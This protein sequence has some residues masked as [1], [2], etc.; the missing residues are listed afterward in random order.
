MSLRQLGLLTFFLL[1]IGGLLYAGICWWSIPV[2]LIPIKVIAPPA[3]VAGGRDW[4]S[5]RGVEVGILEKQDCGPFSGDFFMPQ[6]LGSGVAAFDA[7]GDGRVDLFF[8]NCGGPKGAPNRLYLQTALDH[9]QLAPAGNGLDLSHYCTGVAIGD[10]NRDGKP[11]VLLAEY[12]GIQLLLNAGGG[13]FRRCPSPSSMQ[14]PDWATSCAIADLNGDQLPDLVVTN[15]VAFDPAWPCT[16]PSG[17]REFCPPSAFPGRMTR[18]FKNL[19]SKPGGDP[20]F[21]DVTSFSGLAELPGPG[22][23]V[24]IAD[25]GGSNLP[26][27]LVANDGKPNHLWI[28]QGGF[29][30]SEQALTR[31]LA[32]GG[33]GRAQAGMGIALGDFAGQGRIDVFMTHLAEETHGLWVQGEGGRFR[34]RGA[35]LGVMRTHWRGTGFG[36]VAVDFNLDGR[37]DLALANG[38][39]ASDPQRTQ[40]QG[41]DLAEKWMAGYLQKNQLFQGQL[42]GQ[43]E[44]LSPQIT[45][46]C[47]LPGIH[48]GMVSADLN[49]DGRPDLIVTRLGQRPLILYNQS[50]NRGTALEFHDVNG[51]LQT[52]PIR[53]ILPDGR[54]RILALGGSYLSASEALVFIAP[55][56]DLA[57]N[58]GGV[59]VIWPGGEREQFVL[60][61]EKPRQVVR[62]GQGKRENPST[63]Q[64]AKP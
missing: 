22:L 48:R 18:V 4:F 58:P 38:S 9:F 43:F 28:N 62:F 3:S 33:S 52:G 60:S 31:G 40:S 30:F 8:P 1:F 19:G 29:R 47:D 59:T 26:D 7:D 24:V 10:V 39:V 46:L 15:Y 64:G 11:D 54:E 17:L 25:F 50:Q 51:H 41:V 35:Q 12:S 34:E 57:T 42:N 13:Q 49:A 32:Y 5:E 63:G 6:I 53:L 55:E 14:N 27:I 37:L 56:V 23:G 20:T 36:T 21:E 45:S 61:K 2:Q 44:D 16:G